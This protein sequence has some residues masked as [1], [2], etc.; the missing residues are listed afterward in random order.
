M[1]I[2]QMIER[3]LLGKK[4]FL[5]EPVIKS[6]PWVR[7]MFYGMRDA[8]LRQTLDSFTTGEFIKVCE[9]PFAKPGDTFLARVDPISAEF[10]QI[11]CVTFSRGMRVI[12]AFVG[13]DRFVALHHGY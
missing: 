2:L 11:R 5:L 4:L 8:T 12:G 13:T 3:D 9:N 7:W 6:D 1:S 10:W